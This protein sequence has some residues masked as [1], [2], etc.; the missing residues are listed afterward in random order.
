[1]E[2]KQPY[3]I[4]YMIRNDINGKIYFGLTTEEKGFRGRYKSG[5]WWEYTDN[6]HLRK[7]AK[8][9]GKE[10]FT[11]VEQFDI[12]YSKEE[13]NLLE[14]L[15]I[16]MYNTINPNFGYNKRRG[17]S[18]GKLNYTSKQK[19]SEKT[20]GELNPMYGKKHTEESKQKISQELKGKY[21]G[22]KSVHYG[23]KHSEERRQ[24]QSE[25]QKVSML[26]ES[27]PMYGKKH[28]DETRKLFS[29]QRKGNTNSAKKV[30]CINTGEIFNSAKEAAQYFGLVHGSITR[31]C[32]GE[33]PSIKGY[34]FEYV[35]K[36]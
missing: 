17:G 11:V 18:N 30:V 35:E 9:Y 16:C 4:I 28:K 33:R 3:G 2:D 20:K 5:R 23:K 31:V 15:Y 14:D 27:N 13:L 22:E 6:D 29:Q 36:D 21:S 8:K 25:R 7:S 32:R 24:K 34:K 12:G 19:I 26:G 1:M 10:N